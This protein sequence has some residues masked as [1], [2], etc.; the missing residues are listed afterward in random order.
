TGIEES[1]EL[2]LSGE[3]GIRRV[4][5][6]VVGNTTN[7]IEEKKP[8]PGNNVY[9]TIDLNLQKVAEETLERTITELSRGGTFE[10]EWGDFKFGINRSKGRPYVNANSGAVVVLDVNTG[11]VLAMASYPSY[12]LNL[13]STGISSS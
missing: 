5:V 13:F 9:L 8:V 12:D 11:E 10:S 4:E 1:Y 3:N 7:V 2:E 6:D